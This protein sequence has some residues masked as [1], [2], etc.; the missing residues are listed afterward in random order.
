ML[1]KLFAIAIAA[2]M[3]FSALSVCAEEEEEV[4]NYYEDYETLVILGETE[5]PIN[6]TYEYS[7]FGFMPEEI[8]KYTF[9][10]ENALIALASNNGMWVTVELNSE[11]VNSDSFVWEC[12][13]VGQSIMF[14]LK[15]DATS[16]TVNITREDIIIDEITRTPYENKTTPEAFTFEGNVDDL[17]Y[18]ETFD[19]I[20]DEAVLGEDGF[21]HLNSADG[22][23]LYADLD[24]GLMSLVDA[25]N[26]GQLIALE[27]DEN[28]ELIEKIDFTE[29][30]AEYVSCMDENGLYPLTEDLIYV[31][32]GVGENYN[33]YGD[34]E[35][36]WIGGSLD[37]AWMFACYY[38]AHDDDDTNSDTD[39]DVDNDQS[40]S[41]NDEPI[42]PGDNGNVL[43]FVLISVF[44]MALIPVVAKA[45]K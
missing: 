23:I 13:S 40:G 38:I 24:D 4:I 43:V 11:T 27:Y 19:D 25:N 12:T 36:A 5:C 18:V 21:Y 3:L 16:V 45:R 37:D 1:K 31:Y 8:G 15:S 14:A 22:P 20:L 26:Y 17:L 9:K 41:E 28:G 29:A 35:D 6:A 2:L 30:F 32:K 39:T 44:S 42:Q 7:V 34:E 10:A 33:W